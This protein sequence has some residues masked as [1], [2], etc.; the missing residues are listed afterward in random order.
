MATSKSTLTAEQE[1]EIVSLWKQEMEHRVIAARVKTS[2]KNVA[3]VIRAAIVRENPERTPFSRPKS[4]TARAVKQREVR[5]ERRQRGV[6]F[7]CGDPVHLG[8]S[9]CQRHLEESRKRK[10]PTE[11]A[12]KCRNCPNP[13]LLGKTQCGQCRDK[14]FISNR[15]HFQAR[16]DAGLC[17]ICGKNPPKTDR[18][19]CSTCLDLGKAHATKLRQNREAAGLCLNCGK[20]SRLPYGDSNRCEDCYFKR[21][22]QHHFATNAEGPALKALFYQSGSR[23][24]YSGRSLTAGLDAQLDHRI[25][26]ARGGS[27]T[28]DNVQ[29]VHQDVNDMKGALTEVQFLTL[30]A[31]IYRHGLLSGE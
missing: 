23:C 30:V 8:S 3:R 12:S 11:S 9:R 15:V 29:W 5:D 24:A 21:V 26:V 25:P 17:V 22:S 6:C 13:P 19:C 27:H 28:L 16:L 31:E 4:Q 2:K 14:A 20:A 18:R 7:I 10:H 1:A